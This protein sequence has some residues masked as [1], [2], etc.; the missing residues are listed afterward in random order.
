MHINICF[1]KEKENKTGSSKC[2]FTLS[3]V[4]IGNGNCILSTHSLSSTCIMEGSEVPHVGWC[5]SGL[6]WVIWIVEASFRSSLVIQDLKNKDS[7]M[8]VQLMQE[9]DVYRTRNMVM[10]KPLNPVLGVLK[11][12]TILG[13]LTILFPSN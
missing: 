10:L 9:V 1:E 13:V 6:T 12:F 11:H 5:P 4:I 7:I 2:F 3:E 8:I